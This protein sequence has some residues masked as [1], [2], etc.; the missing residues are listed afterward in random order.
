MGDTIR[1]EKWKKEKIERSRKCHEIVIILFV[2]FDKLPII[3]LHLSPNI[4]SNTVHY[5][6]IMRPGIPFIII[7][8]INKTCIFGSFAA[9]TILSPVHL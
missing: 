6:N 1:L 4:I 2:V 5:L 9:L 7:R 3:S 8:I